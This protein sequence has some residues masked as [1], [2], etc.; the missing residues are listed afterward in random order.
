MKQTGKMQGEKQLFPGDGGSARP[1]E[2]HLPTGDEHLPPFTVSP[3]N[4]IAAC[5]ALDFLT[6][7]L[8]QHSN[9]QG[10]DQR[11][12]P[13]TTIISCLQTGFS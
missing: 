9:E 8:N 7:K 4:E 10:E 12:A 6:H 3:G 11:Y 2:L 5:V 13:T 1:A